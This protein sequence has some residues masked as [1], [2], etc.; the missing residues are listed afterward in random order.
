MNSRLAPYKKDADDFATIVTN[1]FNNGVNLSYVIHF[2]LIQ[3]IVYIVILLYTEVEIDILTGEILINKS[4]L[5]CDYGQSLN[6]IIDIGQSEGAFVMSLGYVLSENVIYDETS[7][8]MLSKGTWNYHVPRSKDIPIEF[9]VDILKG[10]KKTRNP[11]GYLGSKAVGESMML[12][13]SIKCY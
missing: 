12:S 4:Q 9:N 3:I 7:G 8:I 13:A 10:D 6:P 5:L 2:Q 1:A 11:L